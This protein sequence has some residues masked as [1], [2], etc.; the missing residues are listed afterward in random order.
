[1]SNDLKICGIILAKENSNRFPGKNWHEVEGIPMFMHGAEF[2]S[3][4][5]KPENVFI[6]TDSEQVYQYSL[7]C[8]N[9]IHREINATHDE[10]PYLDI[11]RTVY[12]QLPYSYDI[13]ISVLANSINHNIESLKRAIEIMQNDDSIDEVRSFDSDGKQSGIFVFRERFLLNFNTTLHPMASI[14]DDGREIHFKEEL[15]R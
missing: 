6:A 1:M 11:L 14:Q 4:I 15:L 5:I 9:I 10:Q 13:I 7:R 12:M 2:I 3:S 8:Y